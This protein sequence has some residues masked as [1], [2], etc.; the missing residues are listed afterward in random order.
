[1][2]FLQT[3]F[4]IS[5]RRAAD[6]IQIGR[7]SLRYRSTARDQTALRMRLRDLAAA[8]VRY[9]YRRL[10]VLLR[11]EGWAVNHKRVYRLYRLE[12]LGLRLKPRRKRVS[13]VR[14]VAPAAT[15]PNER[16]AMDFMT[17]SLYDG[18]R[19]RLLTLVDTA[20][21][22]CPA[23]EVGQSLTG[24]RV[25]A[26]LNR[27]RESRGVP[28]VISVDNGPEFVSKAVDAWAHA[29]GV[30]LEFN[31]PGTPTDNPS[32]EAFNGRVRDECLSQHWFTSLDDAR[33]TI[34][35]WRLDYNNE[36]PHGALGNRTPAAFA[37]AW[38][39]ASDSQL[40]KGLPQ[41]VERFGNRCTGV[42]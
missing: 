21:R 13:A 23:I 40:G 39:P 14:V 5:E 1:V 27:L 12:G 17:D 31:R 32:I 37:A 10:H 26:M 16:W 41:P 25:V 24:Q 9:G 35:T 2:A 42:S 15:K 20:T 38:T 36:R 6:V 22:E 7:S 29:H 30:Q 28:N 18:R 33:H 8:R 3:G 4:R 34:E 11:R 19:F